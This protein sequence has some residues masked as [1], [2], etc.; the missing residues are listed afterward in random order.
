LPDE[1]F[2]S[3]P[4]ER[5][6]AMKASSRVISFPLFLLI[7]IPTVGQTKPA[8]AA[9]TEGGCQ[10]GSRTVAGAPYTGMQETVH[11]QTLADGTR[12][13]RKG[14]RTQF[15]R[16]SQG[17][18]RQEIYLQI[19]SPGAQDEFQSNIT[20]RDPVECVV[21]NL[22]PTKHIAERRAYS[23]L[24]ASQ[25]GLVNKGTQSGAGQPRRTIPEELRPKSSTEDLGTDTIEGLVVQGT[26]ITTTF[27]AGSQGNDRPIVVTRESWIS[28][29]LRIF[30][31]EKISDPRSGETIRRLTNIELTEPSADLFRVTAD[32]QIRDE[33]E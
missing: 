32:Y 9:Q 18:E 22:H 17:R 24:G 2:G 7:A 3:S 19:G 6:T 30:V 10:L 26:K 33:H 21:Y 1:L 11:T 13:E 28:Q 5:A 23:S 8:L 27:P 12:I 29:E 25:A 16:D 20:I 14:Q 15:Y 31:L 4:R